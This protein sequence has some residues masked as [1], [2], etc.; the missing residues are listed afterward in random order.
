MEAQRER[1]PVVVVGGGQ[2]GLATSYYLSR[3]G[4]RHAV[5][6]ASDRIG[7]SWRSRW[8]TL[9]LFTPARIDGLPGLRFPAR[10]SELPGKDQM[11]DYLEGYVEHF[12]LPVRSGVR[13]AGLRALENGFLLSTT[14]G[15]VE[16]DQV[17]VATG[18]N[19]T[20]RIPDFAR[21]LDATIRQLSAAD[22]HDPSQ[23]SPG[24]VLV[25]GAGNSGAEIA[26]EAAHGHRTWLAG[27]ETGLGSPRYFARPIWWF[28][29]H[30]LTRSTPPGRRMIAA[31]GSGGAPRMRIRPADLSAAGVE[32]VARLSGTRDGRPRL[33][34]GS[35]LEVA[36]V[37]WCTGFVRDFRW[38]EISVFDAG[39][40]P[41]H[42]RG[43]VESAPGLYFVGLP[44]LHSLASA[45]IGGVGRDAAYV[46]KRVTERGRLL[47]RA[48]RAGAR[49]R[50]AP[51][52]TVT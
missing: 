31:A 11:A 21:E 19:Q 32:R 41:R 13:V 9:H 50:P 27:R 39:G 25:V 40:E 42:S 33:E 14:A 43:V 2:A 17:V 38:I 34:D 45:L 18:A 52:A 23:L 46:A 16:A 5:L 51:Q 10:A 24:G 28:G 30:V 26:L 44:Y 15:E 22:Y 37:V 4:V 47:D 20:P 29:L 1:L 3:E 6:D 8:T 36:N 35:L 48:A 7:D 12:K 49:E